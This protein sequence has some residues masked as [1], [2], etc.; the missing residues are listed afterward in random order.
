MISYEH[1]KK[2]TVI[3]LLSGPSSGKSVTAHFLVAHMKAKGFKVEYVH[4]YAKECVWNNMGHD[5]HGSGGVFTEQDFMLANQNQ[6]LRRLVGR[7]VDFV[8][9]DTS[10][11]LGLAYAPDWYPPELKPLLL[12]IYNSYNNINIFIARGDIPYEVEGRNQTAEEAFAKDMET[13]NILIDNNIPF[14]TITQKLGDH[15]HVALD[16]LDYLERQL[17]M[18]AEPKTGLCAPFP[19][20]NLAWTPEKIRELDAALASIGMKETSNGL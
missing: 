19:G 2:L 18:N 16:S 12:S 8:V 7:D 5:S 3:N 1:N 17:K 15:Q 11:L 6:L 9:T 14:V 20:M 4:E 13:K 10:L